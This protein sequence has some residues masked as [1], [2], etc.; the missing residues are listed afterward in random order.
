MLLPYNYHLHRYHL[1]VSMYTVHHEAIFWTAIQFPYPL[2]TIPLHAT[3]W[4]QCIIHYEAIFCW[5]SR[6]VI[7]WESIDWC[8]TSGGCVYRKRQWPWRQALTAPSKYWTYSQPQRTLSW[9]LLYTLHQSTE[10]THSHTEN[11]EVR[12]RFDTL[13]CH[14][15]NLPPH[16]LTDF[17]FSSPLMS[18][19]SSQWAVFS[20]P[21][22]RAIL[23]LDLIILTSEF[24]W[25]H[26]ITDLIWLL[27][28]YFLNNP[29]N[30][31]W[32]LRCY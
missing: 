28:N 32:A 8:C 21:T 18:L 19:H 30:W 2:T 22:W 29:V 10:S 12:W 26:K 15:C 20:L 23:T 11:L 6:C 7:V 4:Y 14:P 17:M 13:S 24:V 25:Q 5:K 31:L 3:N 9:H 1:L 16:S 27:L